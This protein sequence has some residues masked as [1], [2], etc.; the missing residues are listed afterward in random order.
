MVHNPLLRNYFL[1]SRHD[2]ADCKQ[3]NCVACAMTASFTDI[4]AT[5]KLDGHGPVDM[6]HKSWTKKDVS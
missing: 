6:L 1:S 2:T 4:L 3:E 5:E